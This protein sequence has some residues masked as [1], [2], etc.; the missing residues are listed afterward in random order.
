MGLVQI[1]LTVVVILGLIFIYTRSD[2][3][4]DLLAVKL[5]GYYVLGSFRFNLDNIAIP[6]GFL[7]YLVVLHPKLNTQSKLQAAVLGLTFFMV[8]IAQPVIDNYFYQL[9]IEVKTTSVNLY[10]YNFQSDWHSLQQQL[11]LPNDVRLED[12]KAEFENDGSMRELGYKLIC[13]K[14]EGIVYY[15]V[16]LAKKQKVYVI[17]RSKIDQYIQYDRLVTA[18]RFFDIVSSLN[19]NEIKPK[20]EYNWYS[21]SCEGVLSSYGIK[22][23]EKFIIDKTG[24]VMPIN[25][26]RLPVTGYLIS[27]YGMCKINEISYEGQGYKDYFFDVMKD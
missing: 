14:D 21:I 8:G 2:R 17:R 15:N 20:Q 11:E 6:L 5:F 7:I 16:N 3:S 9:P 4:E 24:E 25:N 10:D 12:F 26:E 22:E 18:Q 23:R 19:I 1:I 13:Q 27:L